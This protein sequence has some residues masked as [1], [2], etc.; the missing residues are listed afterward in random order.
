MSL[1]RY[2]VALASIV[3]LL[4]SCKSNM[5][6]QV[7]EIIE[8]D[9]NWRF[10]M[11]GD[12]NWM[13]SKVPGCVH[14]DLVANNK[15]ADPFYRT[16]E[17]TL[18]W[19]DK[20]NWIYRCSFQIDSQQLKYNQIIVRFHGLD[21]YAKVS[22]NHQQILQSDNM[23]RSWKTP[24]KSLLQIGENTLEIEFISPITNGLEK[25]A[26]NGY[27]LPAVNDL[28]EIGELGD[29]KI[30][31]F[32]RKAPYQYGWD[33]GP[34]FV[35]MGI[36]RPVELILCNNAQ[37]EHVFFKQVDISARRAKLDAIIEIDAPSKGKYQLLIETENNN[38]NNSLANGKFDLE[39]GINIVTLPVIVHNPK[40]WWPNGLGEQ[41]LNKFHVS[42]ISD[43]TIVDTLSENIGLRSLKLIIEPDSAGKSFYF[44]INGRPLF[45]K[46]ANYIPNDN[47]LDRVTDEKYE[48][49][50]KSAADANMNMLRVWG[51]GIYENDI[52]YNLCD[53]YGILLWHD[54]MFACS[55][56]PGNPD[57]LENV[58]S[59]VIENIKRLRNH[60][61]IALWCGNNEIDV[62]WCQGNP[63]CGWSWKQKYT[64]QQ[65]AEI[66]HN[67][68]TL[69]HKMMPAIIDEFDNTR[70]YW[71]SSPTADW[72]VHASY[73]SG[74][75]DMHYWGV[76][77][78]NEPFDAFYYRI[79]R[80]MSEYGF[81][82]FP[83]LQTVKKF[84][85]PADRN[86]QSEV[87]RS[88]QRSG[89]GNQRIIDYMTALYPIPKEFEKILY[90]SQVMQAEAIKQAINAHRA[91]KPFCMG[92]LYW[93]L[94]DCWPVASW[95]SIDY[96]GRWKA[97]HYFA[98]KAYQ[99]VTISFVPD[100]DSVS[101]FLNNDT[102]QSK[103]VELQYSIIDFEG[104]ELQKETLSSDLNPDRSNK[105]VAFNLKELKNK[106]KSSEVVLVA[107]I[108]EQ[109]KEIVAD[110][111][112]FEIPKALKLPKTDVQISLKQEGKSL[113]LELK[114]N[115]L[116]KNLY[117]SIP[118]I[119]VQFNDNYFDL[120]P[121]ESRIISCT[122]PD[123]KLVKEGDVKIMCVNDII[124]Q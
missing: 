75:G 99:S 40:L 63:D 29:K 124:N 4:N 46:G 47:F 8:L 66:W 84:T 5:S 104:K 18:Q 1:V 13:P 79:G 111:Y 34:R 114:A 93:Q 95:S 2:F 96:Y 116:V 85:L 23:F 57:F 25:L 56:Y 49:V 109:G 24:I 43:N 83:D 60:A 88:H 103:K 42:L 74:S 106:F 59:E 77:H 105:V 107:K 81:Q 89:Y 9:Q 118:D 14:T 39:P 19:I 67:Y 90:V 115:K 61:S 98:K 72:G 32:T 3:L 12:S 6:Y 10:Q 30:S 20:K 92:T 123:E 44:E 45:A 94:N 65:Q 68:D 102:Y 112:Y 36:W 37:I 86:I 62:A 82:S 122:L 21:T 16:N 7:K 48:T 120:L 108:L 64:P 11:K 69:F 38:Q 110:N 97:L 22:L 35:T 58:K 113:I 101:F 52:F 100:G 26:E 50:V 53:K 15:I 117:V 17:K 28:S 91:K 119:D 55:M 78:G 31:V 73:E 70:T 76:W 33:W 87:M 51:G 41:N 71:P 80:F 27:G 54:F 121:G